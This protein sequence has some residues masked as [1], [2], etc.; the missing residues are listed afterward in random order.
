MIAQRSKC[1]FPYELL[2]LRDL[3]QLLDYLCC[4]ALHFLLT[5]FVQQI[6]SK[7]NTF[8]TA[9]YMKK[10]LSVYRRCVTNQYRKSQIYACDKAQEE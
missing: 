9:F 8:S 3:Q 2:P 1:S 6:T 7:C 10:L 5:W 4:P